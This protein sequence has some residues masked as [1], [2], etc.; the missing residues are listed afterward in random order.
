MILWLF[1]DAFQLYILDNIEW[2]DK[3]KWFCV[4]NIDVE[5]YDNEIFNY[6]V[7][8]SEEELWKTTRNQSG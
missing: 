5:E 2:W 7:R 6:Y 1:K 3:F 8:I 4:I